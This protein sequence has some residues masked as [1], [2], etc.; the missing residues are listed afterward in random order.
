MAE[1]V[2]LP[3][4]GEVLRQVSERIARKLMEGKKL[5]DTEV[6]ILLIGPDER[7]SR[8][9]EQEDRRDERVAKQKDRRRQGHFG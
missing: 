2:A 5:T 4:L 8:P 9:D 1:A 7:V 6:I 3:V